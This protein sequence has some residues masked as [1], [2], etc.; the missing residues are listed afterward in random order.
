VA[1]RHPHK[2]ARP[3]GMGRLLAA[4]SDLVATLADQVGAGVADADTPEWATQRGSAV[5]THVLREVQVWRAA[6]QV[7][8]DDRRPT[9]PVQLHKAARTW[10]RHLDRQVAGDLPPALQEWGRLL[11]Q[12]IPGVTRM[13]SPP[14]SSTGWRRSPVPRWTRR[15]CSVP[16]PPPVAHC[17]MT[18]PPPRCGGGSAGISPRRSP[19]TSTPTIPTPRPGP[20]A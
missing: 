20:R 1:P 11:D 17:L 3:P 4:R 14:R 10:Q 18:M 6:M 13:R 9:G 7:S 8:P 5:P 15:S 19:P 12:V 16:P 2:T